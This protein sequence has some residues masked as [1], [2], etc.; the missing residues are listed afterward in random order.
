VLRVQIVFVLFTPWEGSLNLLTWGKNII[1]QER[2][3]EE[4]APS[5]LLPKYLAL[6]ISLI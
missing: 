2:G 5:P 6:L 3:R 4:L 1:W